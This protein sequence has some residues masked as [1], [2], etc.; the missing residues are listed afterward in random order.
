M[1]MSLCLWCC[2]FCVS[3]TIIPGALIN[4]TT[5]DTAAQDGKQPLRVHGF[6]IKIFSLQL[7]L[8]ASVKFK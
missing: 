2:L 7:I 1:I 8:N 6:V 3:V 5:P 4:I